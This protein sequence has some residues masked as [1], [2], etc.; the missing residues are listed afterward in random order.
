MTA[1]ARDLGYVRSVVR[2]DGKVVAVYYFHDH[3][4][5]DAIPGGDIMGPGRAR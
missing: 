4:A 5:A 1:A 2:P 3:N